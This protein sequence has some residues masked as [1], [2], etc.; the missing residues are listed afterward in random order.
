MDTQETPRLPEARPARKTGRNFA[1]ALGVWIF[2]GLAWALVQ[3]G[4]SEICYRLAY[5]ELVPDEKGRLYEISDA[6][7]WPAGIIYQKRQDVWKQAMLETFMREGGR[8]QEA[9]LQAGELLKEWNASREEPGG[10]YEFLEEQ[11]L[12]TELN[13]VETYAIYGGVC[14]GWGLVVCTAGMGATSLFLWTTRAG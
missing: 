6:V 9:R 2:L 8:S 14:L 5:H 4:L 3:F 7:A 1:I 11:G 13:E 10:L 12:E